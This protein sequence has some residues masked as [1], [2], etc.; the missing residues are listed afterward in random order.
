MVPQMQSNKQTLPSPPATRQLTGIPRDPCRE[1]SPA[2]V[3]PT[4]NPSAF[5]NLQTIKG[6]AQ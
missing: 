3:R 6:D 4:P 2:Q 5:F 1:L